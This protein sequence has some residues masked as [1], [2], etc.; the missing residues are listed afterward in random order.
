MWRGCR[1]LPPFTVGL[2]G[3]AMPQLARR[4]RR[5]APAPRPPP[6]Q[7]PGGERRPSF[8]SGRFAALIPGDGVVEQVFTSGLGNFL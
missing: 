4:P 3:L 2:Q 5:A 6:D 7:Q 1:A 8:R